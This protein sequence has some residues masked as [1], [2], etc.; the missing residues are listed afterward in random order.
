MPI[1]SYGDTE[2]VQ[3]SWAEK[4]GATM[5]KYVEYDDDPLYMLSCCICILQR[6]MNLI[7]GG[8]VKFIVSPV[9]QSERWAEIKLHTFL[10]LTL[11]GD[12]L[13]EERDR[14]ALGRSLVVHR[15]GLYVTTRWFQML[16]VTALR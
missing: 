1:V 15:A 11:D 10:A 14:Y 7:R 16:S 12:E 3:R 13:P 2:K 6:K 9:P 8:T 5:E 4:A